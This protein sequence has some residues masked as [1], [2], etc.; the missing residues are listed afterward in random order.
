MAGMA[1]PLLPFWAILSLPLGL[2]LDPLKAQTKRLPID[3][4][5][6][7]LTISNFPLRT[8]SPAS[9]P[10]SQPS[11]TNILLFLSGS[12]EDQVGGNPPGEKAASRGPFQWR[13]AGQSGSSEFWGGPVWMVTGPW[14]LWR[15]TPLIEEWCQQL[16]ILLIWFYLFKHSYLMFYHTTFQIF[17]SK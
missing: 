3:S 4:P 2:P 8:E 5:S 11:P 9:Q 15:V 14:R 10:D 1:G 13:E 12:H 7:L 6:K 17:I 16:T